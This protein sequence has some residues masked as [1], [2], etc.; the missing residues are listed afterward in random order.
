M[1]IEVLRIGQRL[2][3]DDRV[4]TH[5]ALVSRAFGATKILMYDANPEIKDT[6][7]KVNKIWGGDFQVEIIE[8]WKKALRSKKSDSYKIVHLTMYGENI[9]TIETELKREDKILVVVGAEKVPREVYDIADYNIAIGNQPHSEISALAILLDR[10]LDG[11]QLQ[12]KQGNAQR[13]II[14]TKKGK[15]VMNKTID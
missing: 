3:R 5:V 9:N 14:P 6:V 8:D 12:K 4:T 2:V 10:I 11:K 1:K 13:E 7:S 15:R